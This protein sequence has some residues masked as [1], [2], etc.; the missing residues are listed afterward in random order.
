MLLPAYEPRM[1]TIPAKVDYELSLEYQLKKV[2]WC[3]E[4]LTSQMLNDKHVNDLED[5]SYYMVDT[6]LNNVATLT[7]YYFSNV[8]Y[9]LIGT[10]LDKPKKIEFRG[11]DKNNYEKRK[12]KIID[13]F[14]IGKL[15]QGD[16]IFRKKYS[17][18]CS[19]NIDQYF[20]FLKDGRYEILY[21]LNNYS[22]HNSRLRGFFPKAM[23]N[24]NH[25][26]IKLHFLRFT[27]DN[28]FLL[29]DAIITNLL[30]IDYQNQV[31]GKN[32]V[33]ILDKEFKVV[34]NLGHITFLSDHTVTYS[35]GPSCAGITTNSL[36]YKSYQLCSEITEIL[37]KSNTGEI[38]R[39]K[40]LEK[41][42]EELVLKLINMK[43]F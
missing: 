2:M 23:G 40:E 34:N 3:A 13:E 19:E 29:K 1:A 27:E 15:T 24:K 36:I 10:I 43:L 31:A 5:E 14:K 28:L 38:T 8:I 6:L 7:E 11:F 35:I 17:E 41:L 18:I 33:N 37:L 9:S 21:E 16:D 20:Q 25:E 26:Y 12:K 30:K 22:K 4:K 32:S 42:K 39:L